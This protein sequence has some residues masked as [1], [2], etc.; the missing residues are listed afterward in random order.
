MQISSVDPL[1]YEAI[2]LMADENLGR[3]AAHA[4]LFSQFDCC[5]ECLCFAWESCGHTSMGIFDFP[6]AIV[7]QHDISRF[8]QLFLQAN[9][10]TH[11]WKTTRGRAWRF[12]QLPNG[13]RSDGRWDVTGPGGRI[14]HLAGL[15]PIDYCLSGTE[16]GVLPSY[17]N[18]GALFS[19]SFGRVHH[20]VDLLP[21]GLLQTALQHPSRRLP[22]AF[23]VL[24]DILHIAIPSLSSITTVASCTSMR[25]NGRILYGTASWGCLLKPSSKP[26]RH[27]ILS[28]FYV[29]ATGAIRKS[30]SIEEISTSDASLTTNPSLASS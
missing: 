22:M 2:V 10:F 24:L 4:F 18:P 29:L 6:S 20:Q 9:V 11:S 21:L 19:A 1:R 30:G 7:V 5:A 3:V 25:A 23:A 28:H 8:A 17:L 16:V 26:R 27:A 14:P 15:R 12:P 13:V